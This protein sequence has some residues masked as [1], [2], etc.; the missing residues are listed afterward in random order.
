MCVR[1]Y[2]DFPSWILLSISSLV[3]DGESNHNYAFLVAVPTQL[4]ETTVG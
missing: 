1:A 2:M 4:E 3:D